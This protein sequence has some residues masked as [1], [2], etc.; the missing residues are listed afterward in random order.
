[1][2]NYSTVPKIHFQ[3]A[4]RTLRRRHF[5]TEKE[6]LD[7]FVKYPKSDGIVGS[8]PY[9]W[10]K[11]I[12]HLP[13][14]QKTDKIKNIYQLFRETFANSYS[15]KELVQISEKFTNIL[16]ETGVISPENKIVIKKRNV[17]GAIITGAYTIKERG[18]NKSL[19]PLFVKM[20]Y[21]NSGKKSA[22]KEGV[23][24]ETALGLHLNRL[25]RDEHIL[26]PFFSDTKAKFMVS[27]YEIMP[28]NVKVP[29]GLNKEELYSSPSALKNY[30]EKLKTLTKDYIDFEKF[31]AKQGF[32]HQDLHNKNIIVTRNKRGSLIL[33]LID[34]GKIVKFTEKK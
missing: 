30:F 18:K 8:L 32:E 1:M 19:E 25:Y 4:T 7:V 24:S 13:K 12:I 3:G 6:I 2:Q 10:L 9:G 21:D 5:K 16:R 14:E 26:C 34:L 15:K 29:R 23:F 28:Q 27:R 22:D 20:F 33:K 11:N 31:L 17:D